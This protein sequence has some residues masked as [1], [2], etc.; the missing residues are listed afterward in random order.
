MRDRERDREIRRERQKERERKFDR[1]RER[2]DVREGDSGMP[3]VS[4][5]YYNTCCIIF[6]M[7]ILTIK[8]I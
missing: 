5:T 8:T 1:R 6:K 3:A 7:I 2:D 4:R